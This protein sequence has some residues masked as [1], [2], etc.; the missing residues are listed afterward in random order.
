MDGAQVFFY[1]FLALGIL[2]LVIG[3]YNLFRHI[4]FKKNSKVIPGEVMSY[5]NIRGSGPDPK[6]YFPTVRF[7]LNGKAIEFESNV[8]VSKDFY[9]KGSNVLV[10]YD[11]RRPEKAEIDNESNYLTII[12]LPFLVGLVFTVIGLVGITR[13][14]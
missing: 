10:R 14:S 5:V 2:S 1:A 7:N 6:S 4:S 13:F 3:M 11:V 8:G 9:S 12:S